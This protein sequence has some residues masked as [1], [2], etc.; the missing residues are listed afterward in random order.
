MGAL[1]TWRKANGALHVS[2]LEISWN[3]L[4]AMGKGALSLDATHNVEGLL[5]FKVAGIQTLLDAVARRGV[6]GNPD[7]GIAAALLDRAAKAGNNEA[8]LLGAVV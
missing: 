5:D 6:R 2:D 8:G 7:A 1:E 4:S 3:R